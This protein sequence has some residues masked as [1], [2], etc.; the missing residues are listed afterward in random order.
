MSQFPLPLEFSARAGEPDFI[1]GRSNREA[2]NLLS[3]WAAWS[4]GAALVVGPEASG[5]THLAALMKAQ[6]GEE[7]RIWEDIESCGLDET[8]L[9]HALNRAREGR[10]RTLLLARIPP[11]AW[12]VALP[13]LRSRLLALPIAWLHEPD[14]ALLAELLADR[15]LR[16]GLAVAPEVIEYAVN[17]MDRSY[18]AIEHLAEQIDTAAMADLRKVTVPLMKKIFASEGEE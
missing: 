16:R 14:D 10:E 18:I 9:F 17:R 4:D 15:L 13:D 8:A 6:L 5:K 7:L 2:V 12:H 1:V 3:S 11:G